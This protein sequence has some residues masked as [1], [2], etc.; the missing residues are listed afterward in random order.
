[1]KE[2][3]VLLDF[4]RCVEGFGFNVRGGLFYL[5]DQDWDD[6]S[7]FNEVSF[8]IGDVDSSSISVPEFVSAMEVAVLTYVKE[9]N[10]EKDTVL[11]C[12]SK[13]KLRY[14]AF[15]D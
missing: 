6:P 4:K 2:K 12:L 7:E 15:L 5:L 14:S 8:F 11:N 10:D 13:L 3:Q 9:F 1:M